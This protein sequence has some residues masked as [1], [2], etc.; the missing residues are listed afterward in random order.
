MFCKYSKYLCPSLSKFVHVF[1]SLVQVL[2]K[3]LSYNIPLIPWRFRLPPIVIA[4]S[5][6]IAVLSYFFIYIIINILFL[7]NLLLP[8]YFYLLLLFLYNL[9]LLLYFYTVLLLYCITSIKIQIYRY[10]CY[11]INDIKQ[12]YISMVFS[13]L[14]IL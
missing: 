11:P 8:L 14:I 1:A 5:A 7:Y 12:F 6:V 9:L 10:Y 2:S 3:F 13:S 4:V